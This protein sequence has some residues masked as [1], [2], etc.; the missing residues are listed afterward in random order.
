MKKRLP[1][2]AAL[3]AATL[4]CGAWAQTATGTTSSTTGPGVSGAQDPNASSSTYGTS[5]SGTGSYS[6]STSTSGT[7][8]T[9]VPYDNSSAAY[10]PSGQL[11]SSA[12]DTSTGVKR[13]NAAGGLPAG[14]MSTPYQDGGAAFGYEMNTR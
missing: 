13:H 6:G 10:T 11:S 4:S 9:Y 5:T 1:L 7:S 2:A 14:E 3:I 12:P 8:P